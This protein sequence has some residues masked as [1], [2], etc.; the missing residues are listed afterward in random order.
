MCNAEDVLT[1]L[2]GWLLRNIEKE[3]YCIKH[4]ISYA[5]P[6]QQVLWYQTLDKIDELEDIHKVKQEAILEFSPI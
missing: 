3:D 2:K 4:G 1:D 6:I 5:A